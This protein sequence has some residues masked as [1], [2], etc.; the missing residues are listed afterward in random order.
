[1]HFNL[2]N[3]V[4]FEVVRY[5][6]RAELLIFYY[7]RRRRLRFSPTFP[8][9]IFHLIITKRSK[10]LPRAL[11]VRQQHRTP[12]RPLFIHSLFSKYICIYY[13]YVSMK[14]PDLYNLQ[15]CFIA[16]QFHSFVCF[17]NSLFK[18]GSLAS[19]SQRFVVV[20]I[21]VATEVEV[22]L[23]GMDLGFLGLDHWRRYECYLFVLQ[24]L[25]FRLN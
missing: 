3:L 5:M 2:E 17:R 23:V 4:K 24:F 1:M 21:V 10:K 12:G 14:L 15:L 18:G 11:E 13:I 20:V 7:R 19:E 16:L 22:G 6:G 8:P 25:G 9:V